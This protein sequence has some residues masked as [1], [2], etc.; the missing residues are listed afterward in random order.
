MWQGP[1]PWEGAADS[2]AGPGRHT[3]VGATPDI[4]GP[5]FALDMLEFWRLKWD[6]D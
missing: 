3:V 1:L 6:L 2:A 5:S 4:S